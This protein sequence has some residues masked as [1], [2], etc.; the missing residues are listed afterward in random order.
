[1]GDEFVSKDTFN[2]AMASMEK[3]STRMEQAADR[4]EKALTEE[5]KQRVD[6]CRDIYK[7]KADKGVVKGIIGYGITA[8]IAILTTIGGVYMFV[9]NH[10]TQNVKHVI[11]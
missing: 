2:V 8:I 3:S 9:V 4:I 7:T 5:V 11:K 6:T 10:I 1:M